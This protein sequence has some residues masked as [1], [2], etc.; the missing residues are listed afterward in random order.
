MFIVISV[1]FVFLD[2]WTCLL[3]N[4]LL[5]FMAEEIKATLNAIQTNLSITEEHKIVCDSEIT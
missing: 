2:G 5:E 3:Q 1:S 4:Y